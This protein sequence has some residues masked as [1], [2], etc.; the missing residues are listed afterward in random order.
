MHFSFSHIQPIRHITPMAIF[1]LYSFLITAYT[2]L[3]LLFL[4]LFSQN[5]QA[6]LYNISIRIVRM[7]IAFIATFSTVLMPRLSFS[8]EKDAKRVGRYF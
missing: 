2:N 6:G 3:D 7:I 4:G 8:R 1:A 5:E